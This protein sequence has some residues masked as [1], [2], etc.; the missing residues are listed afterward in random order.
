MRAFFV[1]F[2]IVIFSQC[3]G[4]GWLEVNR[5]SMESYQS[6]HY[7]KA[8]R[9][10]DK[11][12]ALAEKQFGK[13]S[14]NYL[15]TLSNKANAQSASG[16]YL[17]ALDNF[18]QVAHLSFRIYPLP[19]VFQMESLTELSKTFV[20]LADY[21]SAEYYLNFANNIYTSIPERNK[22]HY[23]TA[24][25]PLI[26]AYLKMNALNASLHE[27]KGQVRE[28]IQLLE[29]QKKII[30]EVYP[31]EYRTLPDYQT[32]IN[33][34]AAYFNELFQA[35]EAM[36]Y[37][38]E[39]YELV[40]D[41]GSEK[42]LIFAL[43]NLAGSYRNLEQL[44]SAIYYWNDA[45]AKVQSRQYKNT[46]IHTVI[47]NNLGEVLLAL[48]SYEQAI[49]YLEE[50]LQ[51]Q[52]SNEAINP[53]LYKTTSFNLAEA[54]HW[55]GDYKK[56]DKIYINLMDRILDD[57]VHNFTYLSENEKLSFY[58]NQLDFIDSYKSFA[59]EITGA[60]PLQGTD[61][62]YINSEINGSLYNLQ[63][64][65]KA[66]ILNASQRM[67]NNI[68]NSG[69]STLISIYGLWEE[70]KNMLAKALV[71]EN[72]SAEEIANLKAKIEE[73]EKW[74][75]A[76][77]RNF[78]E[79]FQMQKTTWQQVQQALKPGEAAVEIIRFVDGLLYGALILTPETNEQPALSFVMSTQSKHLDKHFFRQ[80]YNS[81]QFQIQ[82]TSSY[83]VYWQPVIDT[84]INY[85]PEDKMPER[86]YISNDGIYNRINLNSL[87][88]PAT[89][90]YVLDETEV[91]VVSNTRELV[92]DEKQK[93]T[94]NR[95]AALFGEPD[96]SMTS[97]GSFKPLP[98]TKREIEE[99]AKRLSESNWLAKVYTGKDASEQ[100]LKSLDAPTVIHLASHGFFA[101]SGNAYS[102]VDMM[103]RSGIAL[104]GTS[105]TILRGEDGLLTALEL[106]SLN[107]DSTQL[108]VLSACETGL[109]TINYGEGVYGLQRSLQ[110][111]G[112][113]N[114]IMSLWK[115]DDEA[116]Q[117]LMTSF[118][119][120]WIETKDM[121]KAFVEAQKTLRDEY[122][123]PF[124][125]GAFVLAG[126]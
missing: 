97:G 124:Y 107:L 1:I 90:R 126:R 81:I 24:T 108:V 56:A 87:Y 62:P 104:A 16:Q 34:L 95:K 10:A 115:V 85:M 70:R 28:A 25:F 42:D 65:T 63:L 80:Y 122:P 31:D 84:L 6:G 12:L 53:P 93:S 96:F 36:K 17:N 27:K 88:N 100:N 121:Q 66:I 105:D 30:K 101:Q 57:I 71:E 75:T 38:K 117:K 49:N 9:Q 91:V 116:T 112:V 125:W 47:L 119:E 55:S 103:I 111:A 54:F 37:S 44:D 20:I 106:S 102:V 14:N 86:I 123:H 110:V 19:H 52:E 22:A 120:N 32:T 4:Q 74:L 77:S 60:L 99:I 78:T 114:I 69:D 45:L 21:D 5:E 50:S 61:D 92:S 33:N 29:Y 68:L 8:I 67:R 79:G 35:D 98:G 11:A 7:E 13:I 26:D 23:D 76:N 83:K 73:N 2:F 118:Y 15:S 82:D 59:L 48:E 72:A 64:T 39:Y 41:G 40:K 89:K 3:Y 18:R 51:I 46:H 109:G 113:D 94:E 43:Q 58:K